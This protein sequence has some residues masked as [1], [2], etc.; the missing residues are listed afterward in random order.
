[1]IRNLK[2]DLIKTKIYYV[3]ITVYMI[4][5]ITYLETE[6]RMIILVNQLILIMLN[7]IQTV[8]NI[9]KYKLILNRYLLIQMLE[10]I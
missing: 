9:H 2:K 3:L 10:N 4:L 6:W 1:M 7:L 5:K 8:K